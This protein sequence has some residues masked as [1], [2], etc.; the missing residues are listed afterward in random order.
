MF[1]LVLLVEYCVLMLLFTSESCVVLD[2]YVNVDDFIVCAYYHQTCDGEENPIY[3]VS[4][5]SCQFNQL[6]FS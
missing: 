3:F 6:V 2:V 1:M 5:Y 4:Q